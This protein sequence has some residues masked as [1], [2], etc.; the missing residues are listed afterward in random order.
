MPFFSTPRARRPIALT[1]F[2]LLGLWACGESTSDRVSPATRSRSQTSIS[3]DCPTDDLEKART[4]PKCPQYTGQGNQSSVI[5]TESNEVEIIPGGSTAIN[6]TL[7]SPQETEIL[8]IEF[9]DMRGSR[10]GIVP[11]YVKPVYGSAIFCIFIPPNV[12]PGTYDVRFTAIGTQNGQLRRLESAGQ[13][14]DLKLVVKQGSLPNKLKEVC[15]NTFQQSNYV[16]A[17]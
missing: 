2:S 3:I 9:A 14:A 15:P 5:K 12:L 10:S 1:A 17:N 13:A 8:E 7:V 16:S 11:L 4:N 6:L